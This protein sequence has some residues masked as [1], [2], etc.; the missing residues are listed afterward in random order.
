MQD[1]E[2]RNILKIKTWQGYKLFTSYNK[3]IIYVNNN[4]IQ[5]KGV[6]VQLNFWIILGQ[7]HAILQQPVNKWCDID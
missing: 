2:K 6:F 3:Y 1:L 7:V 5:V 4:N